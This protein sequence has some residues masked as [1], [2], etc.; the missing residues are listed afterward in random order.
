MTSIFPI[1]KKRCLYLYGM[2]ARCLSVVFPIKYVFSRIVSRL[3][4]PIERWLASSVRFFLLPIR[5]VPMSDS[6]RSS[7]IDS[8]IENFR[9]KFNKTVKS[10][11]LNLEFL[12]DGDFNL[13][14]VFNG[15]RSWEFN[16]LDDQTRFLINT[17]YL[18]CKYI[19]EYIADVDSLQRRLNSKF[20]SDLTSEISSERTELQDTLVKFIRLLIAR[21]VC[22]SSEAE[23]Y[24]K[25]VLDAFHKLI[26]IIRN[27]QNLLRKIENELCNY[28]PKLDVEF[29]DVVDKGLKPLLQ[30]KAYCLLKKLE[31]PTQSAYWDERLEEIISAIISLSCCV[32]CTDFNQSDLYFNKF[33]KRSAPEFLRSMLDSVTNVKKSL[34]KLWNSTFYLFIIL[35]LTCVLLAMFFKSLISVLSLLFISIFLFANVPFYCVCIIDHLSKLKLLFSE[36]YQN[37]YSLPVASDE[38]WEQVTSSQ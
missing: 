31:S 35:L 17:K 28:N 18:L 1:W 9:E 38:T 33:L 34:A 23:T 4:L 22:A 25:R 29:C 19:P 26:S 14:D 37:L 10:A 24:N 21:A 20:F 15:V 5:F 8:E 27:Q 13:D 7:L 16:S 11:Y 30:K 36:I 2:T 6:F 3:L 12:E 32:D